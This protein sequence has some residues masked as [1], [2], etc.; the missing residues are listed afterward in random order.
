[1]KKL[2]FVVAT[3]FFVAQIAKAGD[4]KDATLKDQGK[5][6]EA[7]TMDWLKSANPDPGLI[8]MSISDFN[9]GFKACIEE[10][11][12]K[13]KTFPVINDDVINEEIIPKLYTA[14]LDPGK[15]YSLSF[16]NVTEK[17][18]GRW[19]RA[20]KR[21]ESGLFFPGWDEPV[22]SV[23]CWNFGYPLDTKPS[24][25]ITV[26]N[27]KSETEYV[28]IPGKKTVIEHGPDTLIETSSTY[29]E[30]DRSINTYRNTQSFTVDMASNVSR[31]QDQGSSCGCPSNASYARRQITCG[32]TEEYVCDQHY[33]EYKRLP[34]KEKKKF[35]DT[36]A[37]KG[38]IF[39]G[40][41]ATGMFVED[42]FD[43]FRRHR[44]VAPRGQVITQGPFDP[45]PS[46]NPIYTQ[47]PNFM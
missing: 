12:Q 6:N 41:V 27:V 22:L 24:P 26:P 20:P 19:N 1:M 45:L 8:T 30:V 43:I 34:K 3:I 23:W 28:Y 25:K 18:W 7:S 31:V 10:F 44:V 4:I 36:F 32:C 11:N 16:W 5:Q 38:L 13:Y 39:L 37:G 47:A 15:I 35:F 46:T 29:K 42:R 14:D 17:K 9:R 21:N 2:F 40:G 33:Q